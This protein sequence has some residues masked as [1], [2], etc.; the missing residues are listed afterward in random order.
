[1]NNISVKNIFGIFTGVIKTNPK[2][3]LVMSIISLLFGILILK[4]GMNPINIIAYSILGVAFFLSE[5]VIVVEATNMYYKNR[6]PLNFEKISGI[7]EKKL[8]KALILFA[9]KSFLIILVLILMCMPM[10]IVVAFLGPSLSGIKL[11]FY[12]MLFSIFIIPVIILE[13]FIGYSLQFYLLNGNNLNNSYSNSRFLHKI[14][15]KLNFSI[16]MKLYSFYYYMIF[17][18][19]VFAKVTLILGALFFTFNYMFYIVASTVV[20]FELI[21]GNEELF[22]ENNSD[23]WEEDF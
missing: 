16:G 12:L 3:F 13:I 21:K 10:A 14:D 8:K 23:M 19:F 22:D 7:L 2:K 9:S 11:F 18:S 4:D 15:K 5:L 17:L 1:M 20:Y 6:K